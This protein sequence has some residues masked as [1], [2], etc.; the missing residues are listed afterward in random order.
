MDRNE[1]KKA[2]YKQNPKAEFKFI[3]KGSAYYLTVIESDKYEPI[4]INFEVP[5]VDMGDADF[6]IFMDAKYL[7]R[8]IKSEEDIVV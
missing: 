3:R 1:I 8:W 7:I 5:V 2:L 4:E 6:E